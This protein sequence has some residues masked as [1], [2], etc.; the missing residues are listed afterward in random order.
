MDLSRASTFLFVPGDRP[1][2]FDK[3]QASGADVV[4]ID[5]EDGV[6][7]SQREKARAHVVSWLST[8]RQAAVRISAI[9]T[10]DHLLDLAA[11]R[12]G[13]EA[14]VVP[15]SESA[16]D[17]ARVA[18]ALSN[19]VKIV[20]LIETARGVVEATNLAAATAVVRLALGNVDLAAE[21]GVDP[22]DHQALLHVRSQLSLASSAAGLTGPIDG[23]TTAIR[24][25]HRVHA[26]A[27]H[28]A[29]LGFRGK[30]CIH[31]HQVSQARAGLA[32]SAQQVAWAES[33]LAEVANGA[34][35]VVGEAMVD[36]PVEER[37]RDIL[38]RSGHR[39][40]AD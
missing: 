18:S 40:D 5:L 27:Q 3:A 38:W 24:D 22:D 2:R 7:P 28:G 32:P 1:E 35:R 13:I 4:I 39:R 12:C 19:E 6:A 14:V 29:S 26:D 21:I 33:I 17:L 20:A 37:A 8:G 31:P 30:L 15:K 36:R 23:V 16:A 25:T 9:G 10:E 11:L 34:A